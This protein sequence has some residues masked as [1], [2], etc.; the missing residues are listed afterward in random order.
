MNGFLT[1][2][3][4]IVSVSTSLIKS[5]N[6]LIYQAN[7]IYLRVSHLKGKTEPL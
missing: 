5:I 4:D 2:N 6:I 7:L 3:A 1:L